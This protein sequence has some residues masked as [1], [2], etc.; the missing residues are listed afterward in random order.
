MIQLFEVDEPTS[1]VEVQ[2]TTP[3]RVIDLMV[4]LCENKIKYIG[5][6]VEV[7]QVSVLDAMAIETDHET[8]NAKVTILM[9]ARTRDEVKHAQNAH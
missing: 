7:Q 5:E 6:P 2:P 1:L 4:Y 3:A 9:R 8:D